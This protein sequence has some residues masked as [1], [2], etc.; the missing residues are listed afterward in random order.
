VDYRQPL[1]VNFY[2]SQLDYL[3]GIASIYSISVSKLV[4]FMI[5]LCTNNHDTF[6]DFIK[7]EIEREKVK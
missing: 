7:K 4:G 1:S 6:I 5:K 3:R 2:K